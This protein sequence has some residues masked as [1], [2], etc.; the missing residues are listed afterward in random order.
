MDWPGKFSVLCR[1]TS[2]SEDKYKYVTT[3]S[4]RLPYNRAHLDDQLHPHN[5]YEFNVSCYF[6]YTVWKERVMTQTMYVSIIAASDTKLS[7]P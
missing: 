5:N 4:L 7:Q 3:V 6:L 2:P 1:T